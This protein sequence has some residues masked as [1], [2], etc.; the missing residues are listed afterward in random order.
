MDPGHDARARVQRP[1]RRLPVPDGAVLRGRARRP[2]A[3]VGR[4]AAVAGGAAG[5]R[6]V[7]DGAPA[8]RHAL[9]AAGASRTWPPAR[10]SCSTRSSSPTWTGPRSRCSPTRCCRGCWSPCT[11]AC[12]IRAAG[13]GRR[14]S[15][16]SSPAAAAAS[17]P[18]SLGWVLLGPVLLL[19]YE[20]LFGD[21]RAGRDRTV[22]RPADSAGGARLAV[23]ADGPRGRRHPRA[24]HPAVH[25]ATGGDLEPDEPHREPAADGL[26][27]QL[28]RDQLHRSA[29]AVLRLGRAAAVLAMGRRS[30]AAR[31][32]AGARRAAVDAAPP[33]C[34]VPAGADARRSCWR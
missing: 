17:T 32:R 21:V 22:P 7:G 11:R 5:A 30:V 16:C 8:R 15:R 19:V 23:V 20:R 2:A 10:C 28:L 13:A 26:L 1:V 14:C 27:A 24:E 4:P 33:L 3:D 12:A 9:A 29:Q 18:A 31:A 6:G 25:R 34:P